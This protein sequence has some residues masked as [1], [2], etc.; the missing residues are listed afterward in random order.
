[1]VVLLNQDDWV[2]ISV[3]N[4]KVDEKTAEKGSEKFVTARDKQFIDMENKLSERGH[5]ISTHR[6]C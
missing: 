6:N 1:M 5:K 4:V 2:Q 3:I